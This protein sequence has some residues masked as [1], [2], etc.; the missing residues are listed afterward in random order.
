MI[1][2]KEQSGW[3]LA[4]M[5]NSYARTGEGDLALE[6]LEILSRTCLLNN[7]YTT[8]NDWRDMGIGVDMPWAPF[9]IDA[10]MG[11]TAAV[12]EMLLFSRP[13]EISLLPALPEKWRRGRVTGLRCRGG[14]EVTIE[15][16]RDA[17][18]LTATLLSRTDQCVQITTPAAPSGRKIA[19]TAAIATAWRSRFHLPH[20]P[21]CRQGTDGHP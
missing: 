11:W 4:H 17:D 3:S 6:C 19:L 5:A 7:L 21:H 10:N 2:L 13:G 15:W 1:G 20:P 14:V 18:V 8:H 9:Q 16:D 12:Q